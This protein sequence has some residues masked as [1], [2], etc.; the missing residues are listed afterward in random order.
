MRVAGCWATIS[1]ISPSSCSRATVSRTGSRTRGCEARARLRGLS[2]LHPA[3][4]GADRR[5]ER[6]RLS[7]DPRSRGARRALRSHL[8]SR[9]PRRRDDEGVPATLGDPGGVRA[10]LRAA[11]GHARPL[12][13]RHQADQLFPRGAPRPVHARPRR[14]PRRLRARRP[15]RGRQRRGQERVRPRPDHA[16]TQPG[17]RRLRDHQ[18]VPGRQPRRVRR[19]A[20]QAPDGAARHRHRQRQTSSPAAVRE[21]RAS[22]SSSNRTLGRGRATNGS[23]STSRPTRSSR[24]RCRSSGCRWRSAATFDPRRDRGPQSSP[25][26]ARPPL[27]EGVREK[28]EEQLER[29][30]RARPPH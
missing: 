17:R 24:S 12:L 30:R 3:R 26:A 6:G 11:P 15:A 22:T 2:Q 27:R 13:A 14:A 23:A 19:G 29:N 20:A 9:H 25:Q 7:R 8:P 10:A 4:P 28:M 5:G 16:R 21:R 1:A 18:A